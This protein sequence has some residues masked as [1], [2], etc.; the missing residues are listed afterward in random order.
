[1]REKYRS[2][3]EDKNGAELLIVWLRRWGK[4]Q[5]RLRWAGSE[6]PVEGGRRR[7]AAVFGEV[8]RDARLDRGAVGISLVAAATVARNGRRRGSHRPRQG[9]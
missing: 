3:P 7:A 2:F 5:W 4:K 8:M 9:E 1:M 6:G